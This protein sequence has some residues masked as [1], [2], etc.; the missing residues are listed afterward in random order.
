VSL[1]KDDI[2]DKMRSSNNFDINVIKGKFVED[3]NIFT[4][5]QPYC[6]IEIGQ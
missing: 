2:F 4:K 5:M 3:K 6:V 1:I